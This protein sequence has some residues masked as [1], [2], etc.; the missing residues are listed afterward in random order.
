MKELDFEYLRDVLENITYWET[1]PETYRQRF[2]TLIKQ[3]D[4]HREELKNNVTLGSVSKCCNVDCSEPIASPDGV[5]CEY[6]RT[7]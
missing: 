5:Y 2:K 3:I 4:N 1:C 6:H 7:M